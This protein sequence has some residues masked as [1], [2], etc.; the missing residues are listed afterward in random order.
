MSPRPVPTEASFD[1]AQPLQGGLQAPWASPQPRQTACARRIA[2]GQARHQDNHAPEAETP[3]PKAFIDLQVRFAETLATTHGLS[4]ATALLDY[5]TVHRRLFKHPSKGVDPRWW[6]FAD[7]IAGD[8][9]LAADKIYD[10]YI[11]RVQRPSLLPGRAMSQH[12]CF[13]FE[14]RENR[15]QFVLH[16]EGADPKGNL[17]RDR[18]GCRT[19]ELVEMSATIA[20]HHKAGATVRMS[21]WLLDIEAFNRL[22]PGEF[23]AKT[24]GIGYEKTQDMGWWGQFLDRRAGIKQTLAQEVLGRAAN[25]A[26]APAACFPL[27]QMTSSVE[28]EHFFDSFLHP[29]SRIRHF[30]QPESC[31]T[32]AAQA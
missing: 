10:T 6:A 5:T 21:S 15:N 24:T 14:Y 12:G 27:R 16:F 23:R 18:I 28:Q 22:M 29:R 19:R 17:G 32:D 25:P 31:P 30:P 3:L 2:A 7:E 26:I 9:D 8:P 13:S 20:C 11:N 1:V 4:F